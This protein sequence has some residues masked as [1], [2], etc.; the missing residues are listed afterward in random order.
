[1]SFIL[2]NFGKYAI[3]DCPFI[4]LFV[5][6]YDDIIVWNSFFCIISLLQME[7]TCDWC[8]PLIKHQ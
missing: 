1:M 7:S 3:S 6:N 8:I 4:L 2:A 5:W